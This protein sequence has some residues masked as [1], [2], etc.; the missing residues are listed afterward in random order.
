MTRQLRRLALAALAAVLGSTAAAPAAT[1]GFDRFYVLGD[2]LTD[3]GNAHRATLGQAPESPP[4]DRL[5]FSNGKVW[6]DHVAKAVRAEG[7]K[8]RNFAYGGA[9]AITNRDPIPDLRAQRRL[10][11]D[12]IDPRRGD[13]GAIWIGGNDL[14]DSIGSS[15]VR[16][17]GR[18]AADEVYAV[19]RRLQ[20][21]GLQ[22][23]LIFNMPNFADIPRY[24][25]ANA[26]RRRS[27]RSGS[28]AYN[29]RLATNIERLRD[30]G[31]E[32]I[33]VDVFDLFA[34]VTANPG[35]YGIENLTKPCIRNG[36]DRCSPA[37][38]RATAFAD[39]IHPSAALHRILGR[40]VIDL[41]SERTTMA[42]LLDDARIRVDAAAPA[43]RAAA[44]VAAVPLPAPALLLLSGFG[45]LALAARRRAR[46]AS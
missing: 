26:E 34:D 45:A 27:A 19:A 6:Y 2:S 35:K 36:R 33:E 42:S 7:G 22:S 21:E 13:L 12:R 41:I 44:A 43:P 16:S 30:R 10:L 18:K 40:H 38:A 20:R 8:A 46:A 37:E 29:A 9:R 23:A 39:Q 25:G 24:A 14:L 4:Y 28:L 17:V 32:V 11:L 3:V 31:L 1:L 5:R 15:R